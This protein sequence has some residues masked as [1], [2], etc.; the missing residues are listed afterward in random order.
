MK[1]KGR[2]EVIAFIVLL[3]ILAA[4]A[5]A[6]FSI[7]PGCH[8]LSDTGDCTYYNITTGQ[9]SFEYRVY[10]RGDAEASFRVFMETGGLPQ[11]FSSITPSEFTLQPFSGRSCENTPGCQIVTVK[12]NTSSLEEGKYDFFVVAETTEKGTILPITLQVKSKLLIDVMRPVNALMVIILVLSLA[13]L[14]ALITLIAKYI[15]RPRHG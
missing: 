10:N 8:K 9:A 12:L 11:N 14:I 6:Q 7:S 13:V 5:L 2:V 15:R 3:V 1:K 4:P